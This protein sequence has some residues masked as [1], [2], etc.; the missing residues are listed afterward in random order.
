VAYYYFVKDI[1]FIKT[2]VFIASCIL[3]FINLP[4]KIFLGYICFFIVL[5]LLV[6][7]PWIITIISMAL[8]KDNE[9]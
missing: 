3:I 8:H 6:F 2:I 1:P 7:L 5:G 9:D 4:L